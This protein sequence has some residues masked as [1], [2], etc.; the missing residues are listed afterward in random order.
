VGVAGATTVSVGCTV[1]V[2]P[3]LRGPF[4]AVDFLAIVF[5]LMLVPPRRDQSLD[6][7]P[8]WRCFVARGKFI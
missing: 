5:S 1:F 3:I 2:T 7:I 6:S 8:H 4:D